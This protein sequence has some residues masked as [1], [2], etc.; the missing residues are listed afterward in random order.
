MWAKRI[1]QGCGVEILLVFDDLATSQCEHL[2]PLVLEDP[3]SG[4][5]TVSFTTEHDNPVM[6][7]NK[8][9][10]LEPFRVEQ[11]TKG[12]KEITHTIA[13]VPRT[14]NRE[15]RRSRHLPVHII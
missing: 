15:I 2:N 14:T 3:P 5:H 6:L 10:R 13:T 8:L 12:L 9:L 11:L 4:P 1:P 7:G